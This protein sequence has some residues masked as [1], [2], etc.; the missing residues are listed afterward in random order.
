MSDSKHDPNR[1]AVT[2]SDGR[3]YTYNPVWDS[4]FPWTIRNDMYNAHICRTP[5]DYRACAEV[6][7]RWGAD[8]APKKS[9]GSEVALYGRRH[10]AGMSIAERVAY[11]LS[12]GPARSRNELCRR[13]GGRKE[14]VLFVVNQMIRDGEV[15]QFESGAL[16]LSPCVEV[17]RGE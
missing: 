9:E 7:E 8:H 14:E 10:Y 4:R 12:F 2:L 1:Y 5:A 3:T 17:P 6:V 13:T 11:W 16:S 15:V